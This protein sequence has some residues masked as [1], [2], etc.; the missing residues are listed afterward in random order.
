M[1]SPNIINKVYMHKFSRSKGIYYCKSYQNCVVMSSNNTINI[2]R[3]AIPKQL[4]TP[5]SPIN[6]N[7]SSLDT[8]KHNYSVSTHS[9]IDTQPSIQS[10]PSGS[11]IG[12]FVRSVFGPLSDK[13]QLGA[14][15]PTV[16]GL[17]PKD[18]EKFKWY[19]LFI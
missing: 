16:R 13:D 5:L 15:S 3:T 18:G 1:Q 14:H 6:S 4:E 9:I 19:R 10:N 2:N 8:S 7:Q 17:V 11:K 12:R